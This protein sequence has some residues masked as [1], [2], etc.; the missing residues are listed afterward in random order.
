MRQFLEK[1]VMAIETKYEKVSVNLSQCR[2]TLKALE[3][4]LRRLSNLGSDSMNTTK[5]DGSNQSTAYENDS[6]KISL[7]SASGSSDG[8]IVNS[9]SGEA[10]SNTAVSNSTAAVSASVS[11]EE[12]VTDGAWLDDGSMTKSQDDELLDTLNI[13]VSG[14]DFITCCLY[15]FTK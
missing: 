14:I 15:Y 13:K 5:I 11:F 6:H 9:S 8:E 1:N 2:K 3:G 10:W 7:I 12:L 4:K